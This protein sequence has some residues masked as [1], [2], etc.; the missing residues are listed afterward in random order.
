M[1]LSHFS[2]HL[3]RLPKP[4]IRPREK[5]SNL[6]DDFGNAFDSS[7]IVQIKDTRQFQTARIVRHYRIISKRSL[8]N[9]TQMTIRTNTTT[10][11]SG[12]LK[13]VRIVSFGPIKRGSSQRRAETEMRFRYC[14]PKLIQEWQNSSNHIERT[15]K[16]FNRHIIISLYLYNY[17]TYYSTKNLEPLLRQNFSVAY[18]E[19]DY[20]NEQCI[21]SFQ[22]YHTLYRSVSVADQNGGEA[23]GGSSSL[24]ISALLINIIH[25]GNGRFI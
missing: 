25:F 24:Q 8:V 5:T 22:L 17:Y 21:L 6:S 18:I 20:S 9:S 11:W 1:Y 15:R 4:A 16:L 10:I 2:T 14:R 19:H 23:I 13:V 7:V 3:A 12:T